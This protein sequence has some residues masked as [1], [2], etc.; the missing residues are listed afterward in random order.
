[1][2]ETTNLKLFKHDNPATNTNMFDI[3][4]ALNENWDKIDEGLENN[5]KTT[6]Q[7]STAK[8]LEI[9]DSAGVK[10]KL[11]VVDGDTQQETSTTSP[12]PTNPSDIRNVGDNINL[13]SCTNWKKVTTTSG[14]PVETSTGITI[15]SSDTNNITFS[16]TST[17]RGVMSNFIPVKNGDII[18]ASFEQEGINRFF[19]EQYDI[20]ETRVKT[21]NTPANIN[22]ATVTAEN[23]GYIALCFA[24]S[25]TVTNCE[26]TNIK[27]EKSSMSTPYTAYNKGSIDIK[28]RNKNLFNGWVRNQ[29]IN[30]TTGNLQNATNSLRSEF[31][32]V[33]ENTNYYI[34]G[35]YTGITGANKYVCFYNKSMEF[36][37]RTSSSNFN[38]L[39]ITTPSSTRYISISRNSNFSSETDLETFISN[40]NVQIEKGIT[41]ST[42]IEPK[43]QTIQFPLSTGQLLHKGDYLANDGIHQVKG[44]LVFDGTESWQEYSSANSYRLPRTDTK[45]ISTTSQIYC[46][47]CQGVSSGFANY[48]YSFFENN[49]NL[50]IKNKDIST[51]S[52]FTTWLTNQHTAGTPVTVE[53]ELKEETTTPYTT[54]QAEQYY[55]LQHLLMYEGYTL[56]EC[57]DTMQP[58]IQVDYLYNNEINN[59]YGNRLD[60]IE[61]RL[62]ILEN[63]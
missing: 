61:A 2:S 4:K 37:E 59:Y 9:T 50:F 5:I 40:S 16:S 24:N 19:I 21:L 20:N 62:H 1:M 23:D 57:I 53:Y 30:S 44:T 42:Y 15:D 29:M 17:Y 6:K 34:S 25:S 28:I 26:I 7:T 52:A 35:L 36:L 63:S 32:K 46:T 18:S 3:E 22:I 38:K 33:D 58:D 55:K 41:N 27:V 45:N 60:D 56:I 47:H 31:I 54:E 10:G 11:D 48:D 14:Y 51:L 12:S 39:A 49:A 43:T 13:F 8:S